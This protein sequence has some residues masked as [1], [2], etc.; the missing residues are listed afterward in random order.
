MKDKE[1]S[2]LMKL[3]SES[4]ISELRILL[5]ESKS[6]IDELEYKYE[7]LSLLHID[8]IKSHKIKENEIKKLK[9]DVE[10]LKAE[11]ARQQRA[12]TRLHKSLYK[13]KHPKE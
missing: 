1:W 5:G 9:E 4:I 13:I 11:V 12:N 10:I 8:L 2:G 3:P 6:I 7:N